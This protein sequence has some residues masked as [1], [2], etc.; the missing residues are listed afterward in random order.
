MTAT[1]TPLPP[2]D[3]VIPFFNRLT[4]LHSTANRGRAVA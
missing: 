4:Q 3:A 2:R 1:I